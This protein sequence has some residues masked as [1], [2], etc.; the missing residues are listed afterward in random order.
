MSESDQSY[1]NGMWTTR[2]SRPYIIIIMEIITVPIIGS[3]ITFTE[4]LLYKMHC[5][6]TLN[7]LSKKYANNSP[8]RYCYFYVDFIDGKVERENLNDFC[9]I[10]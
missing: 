4:Y 9:K 3:A 6:N 8:L 5:L 1:Y 2:I 10:K 7:I